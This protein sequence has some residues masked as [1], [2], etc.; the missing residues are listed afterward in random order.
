MTAE[1]IIVFIPV[2][3]L[4]ERS[5]ETF[6]RR[7]WLVEPNYSHICLFAGFF[8]RAAIFGMQYTPAVNF[9]FL[10]QHGIATKIQ[11]SKPILEIRT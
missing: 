8:N 11:S 10:Y 9:L 5:P 2:C 1:D 6:S 7:N 4:D 3:Q